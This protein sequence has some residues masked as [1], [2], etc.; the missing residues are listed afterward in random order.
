MKLAMGMTVIK[1][2]RETAN[3]AEKQGMLLARPPVVVPERPI[4]PR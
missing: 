2:V 1:R 3:S 4:T